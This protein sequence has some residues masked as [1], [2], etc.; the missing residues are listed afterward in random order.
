M[1]N[2][3]VTIIILNWNKAEDTIEC[4][5][6]LHELSYNNSSIIVI[7]NASTDNSVQKIKQKFPDIMLISNKSNLGFCEGNNIGM[8][9]AFQSG[10][11]YIFLLNNDAVIEKSAHA[12]NPR[13]TFYTSENIHDILAMRNLMDELRSSGEMMGGPAA[14]GPK[15]KQVFANRLDSFLT[16]YNT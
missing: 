12:L 9:Y 15:E 16:R 3:K 13:G 11:E 1:N 8:R 14:F 2:P 5:N 10:A 6:S 4:L 7:D